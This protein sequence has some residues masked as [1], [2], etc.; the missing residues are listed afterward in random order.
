M[1]LFCAFYAVV[2]FSPAF[3]A[4]KTN[5]YE[6]QA[7]DAVASCV[8]LN[9]ALGSAKNHDDWGSLY[10]FS[11]YTMGYLTGI[12]RMAFDTF[13]IAGTKNVKT[14]MVWLERYCAEHPNDSYD[15][16]LQQLVAKLY[17]ERETMAP[18]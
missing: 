13:D 10:G 11:L 9:A 4:D 16:A 8:A 3:A 5:Q 17:R 12:N 7:I 18:E 2:V 15:S 1:R 14:H 6:V